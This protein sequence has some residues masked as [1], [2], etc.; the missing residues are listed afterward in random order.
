M[1][2]SPL[3]AK[4]YLD[5]DLVSS[6]ARHLNS[7]GVPNLLWGNYLLTVY[8]VPTVVNSAD[9]V[10]P[11]DLTE[12]AF[13]SLK[14][15]GFA[16]CSQSPDCRHSGSFLVRPAYTHLHIT[17]ELAISLYR[18][19]DVLWELE[20]LRCLSEKSSEIMSASDDRLPPATLG[21]GQGRFTSLPCDVKIPSA[22]KYCEALILLLG[23]DRNS[24]Y[25]TFWLAMLT[26]I[27]EYV[28]GT[29]IFDENKL[30]ED[31]RKFYHALK[32]V[33]FD[34]SIMLDELRHDLVDKGRLPVMD[35]G[36]DRTQPSCL[37]P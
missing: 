33:D 18:Q 27:L 9:F 16:P 29:E 19:S 26:Y 36:D 35:T 30:Q 5:N 7:I 4:R 13:S 32:T 24:A 22:V 10:I 14:N 25:E 31:C 28:D 6:I 37:I 17:N 34:L 8:G 15:V 23:R 11:D 21:R 2:D 20:D 3:A 12:I 1:A